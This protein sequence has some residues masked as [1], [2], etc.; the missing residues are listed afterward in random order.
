MASKTRILNLLD[1]IRR[2]LS[3]YTPTENKGELPVGIE[4][5]CIGVQRIHHAY[6]YYDEGT[7]R[8]NGGIMHA[9]IRDNKRPYVKEGKQVRLILDS[10][11]N[12]RTNCEI[13]WVED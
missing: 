4:G 1:G 8:V 11:A 7:F 10:T 5:T 12:N 2:E 6:G 9:S 3:A 13:V